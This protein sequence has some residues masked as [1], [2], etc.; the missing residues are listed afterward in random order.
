MVLF[1]EDELAQGAV[2]V[3]DMAA[4]AEDVVPLDGLADELRRRIAAL[5]AR[6][7]GEAAAAAVTPG[8]E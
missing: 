8:A 6:G 3:K 5:E 2:K 1:G 7:S 4:K